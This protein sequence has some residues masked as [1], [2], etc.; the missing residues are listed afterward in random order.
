MGSTHRLSKAIRAIL[1][2]TMLFYGMNISFEEI[3]PENFPNMVKG[4][5]QPSL[6]ST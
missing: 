2:V 3:K 1:K 6:E 5:S 4:N